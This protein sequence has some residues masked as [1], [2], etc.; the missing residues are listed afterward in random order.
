MI[1][2]Y[3]GQYNMSRTICYVIFSLVTIKVLSRVINQDIIIINIER[4]IM[5]LVVSNQSDTVVRP[6][7]WTIRQVSRYDCPRREE[8]YYDQVQTALVYR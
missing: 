1:E 5:C 6:C 3:L 2:N 7:D 8:H 4:S